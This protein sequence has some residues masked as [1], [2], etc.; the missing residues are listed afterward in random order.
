MIVL[1]KRDKYITAQASRRTFN[2][3]KY[4]LKLISFVGFEQKYI[5]KRYFFFATIKIINMDIQSTAVQQNTLADKII[6]QTEQP[7][8]RRGWIERCL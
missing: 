8:R 1:I 4:N 3:E 5:E 6:N 2:L 7:H